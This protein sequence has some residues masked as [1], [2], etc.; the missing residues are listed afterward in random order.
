MSGTVLSTHHVVTCLILHKSDGRRHSSSHFMDK[1]KEKLRHKDAE[2]HRPFE[3]KY[4]KYGLRVLE[5]RE[6]ESIYI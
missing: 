6:M 4:S 5:G 1:K 3:W 2:K